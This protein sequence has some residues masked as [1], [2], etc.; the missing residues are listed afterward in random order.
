MNKISGANVR[1][2][3]NFFLLKAGLKVGL[4]AR[5]G[6]HRPCLRLHFNSM[7]QKESEQPEHPLIIFLS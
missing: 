6:N 3:L 1:R 5:V 2:L 7:Y 4:F